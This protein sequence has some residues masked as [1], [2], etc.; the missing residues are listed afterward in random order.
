M[1]PPAEAGQA[2]DARMAGF[3]VRTAVVDLETSPDLAPRNDALRVAGF[4]CGA[5]VSLDV[6]PGVATALI[7]T[8]LVRMTLRM[9]SSAI[10][11]ATETG[12]GPTP[13]ISHRSP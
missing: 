4:Q 13:G 12:T 7:S 11:R 10:R 9:E 1:V 8:P 6:A 5:L 3:D 2:L